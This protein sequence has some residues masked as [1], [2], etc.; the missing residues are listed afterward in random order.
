MDLVQLLEATLAPA[1]LRK[2]RGFPPLATN[3]SLA[4]AVSGGPDSLALLHLAATAFPGRI[5]ALT[6]DH[7]LRPASTAEAR[8][9]ATLCAAAAIPHATLVWTG[10]K[11]AANLQAA[12]R[13]ARYALMAD[14]C[15]A[16]AVPLLLTAHH[17]DDQAETLLM[18][19]AR[20][21]GST[22]LAGIRPTRA[23]GPGVTLARPLLT[24]R[25]AALAAT[26][27][28]TGW[29][30]VTDPGNDDPRF[31]R[32]RARRLLAATPWLAA[33]RLARAAAHL[34]ADADAL[35]WALD[36]AWAGAATLTPT[37]LRLDTAGLPET[38]RHRL[39]ARAIATLAPGATPR[40]PAVARLV[41]ALDAGRT[42]TLAGVRATSRHGFW[43]F[44][45]APDRRPKAPNHP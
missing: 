16:H 39:A 41:T 38:L 1:P 29:T 14:W 32:T 42:A 31:D 18:R 13:A 20:A 17:A 19:L 10:P 37:A 23:L 8:H 15:R 4:I 25:R 11:P 33:P 12:A 24:V 45:A 27:A 6:V 35:A 9:V 22:G 28:A 26:L 3:T 43:H 21:G 2:G 34:A 36:R 7:A 44:A 5:T 30:P 40:G